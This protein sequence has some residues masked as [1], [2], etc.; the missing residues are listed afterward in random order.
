MKCSKWLLKGR[1]GLL[2]IAVIALVSAGATHATTFGPIP[3]TVQDGGYSYTRNFGTDPAGT[4]GY[5][6]GLDVACPPPGMVFYS[7]FWIG[8]VPY[9]LSTDIR[10][11]TADSLSWLLKVTNATGIT[12]TIEWD[13]T[14]LPATTDSFLIKYNGTTV[15]MRDT[16]QITN[17]GGEDYTIV[18]KHIIP[19]VQLC[20]LTVIGVKADTVYSYDRYFGFSIGATDAFDVG[21]D[22]ACPPPGFVFY[23]Y[24]WITTSPNYLC[25]DI[26]SSTVDSTTWILKIA[27]AY[28]YTDTVK[29]DPTC[30]PEGAWYLVD[31]DN[32]T[33]DMK[34][35]SYAVYSGEQELHIK[36]Y[37]M[38]LN[39]GPTSIVSPSDTVTCGSIN[40][41]EAWVKNFGSQAVTFDVSC[42]ID[43]YASTVNV[44]NLPA[45]DS[46]L[47]A[48]ADWTAPVTPGTYTM[49]VI[50]QLAGDANPAND[51]LSKDI[52]VTC[53]PVLCY[54]ELVAVPDSLSAG[55]TTTITVKAMNCDSQLITTYHN[56]APVTLDLVGVCAIPDEI[57]WGGAATPITGTCSAQIDSCKFVGGIAVVTLAY[58]RAECIQVTATDIDGKTGTSNQICWYPLGASY[59]SVDVPDTAYVGCPFTVTVTPRDIY[60][61]EVTAYSYWI[62]FA[63]NELCVKLPSAQLITGATEYEVKPTNTA[64][65][66]RIGVLTH[67]GEMYGWSDPIVVTMPVIDQPN[68]IYASDFPNDQGCCIV[69][70][71]DFS[72][73]HPGVS[74]ACPTIDYY[75]IYAGTTAVAPEFLWGTVQ[76]T[77]PTEVGLDSM[78]VVVTTCGY[79]G[80]MYFWVQAVDD[81]A[82]NG[83]ISSSGKEMVTDGSHN[84]VH[85]YI[86]AEVNP[87]RLS[88]IKG[89][90][91]SALTG[92][93]VGQAIDNIAPTEASFVRAMDTQ[94]DLGGSITITWN[95]SADDRIVAQSQDMFG[96][97][98]CIYGVTEYL[99]YRDEE[100]VGS[101]ARGISEYVD[102]GVEN[103]HPYNYAI[104]AFDGTNLSEISNIDD[105]IAADNTVLGDFTSDHIVGLADLVLFAD[106]YGL[107]QSDI[108]FDWLYDLDKDG[109]IGLS[110][111]TIFVDQYGTKT[112]STSSSGLNSEAQ[113]EVDV[114]PDATNSQYLLNI[115]AVNVRSLVGYQLKVKYDP[116]LATFVTAKSQGLLRSKG[117]ETPLFLVKKGYGEVT[118][119][120]VLYKASD[121]T[122]P[123][124][125]GALVQLCFVADKPEFEL[126]DIRLIDIDGNIDMLKSITASGTEVVNN[127][128]PKL[129]ELYQNHPNPFVSETAIKY[130][131]PKSTAVRL[132]IYNIAGQEICTLVEGNKEAGYYTVKW[133]GKDNSGL[134]VNSGIYFCRLKTSDRTI[135]KKLIILQ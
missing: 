11:S 24:F 25:A 46:T 22:S 66:L 125:E 14:A 28:Q 68:V 79:T 124:G 15:N 71:W 83:K 129:C 133:D 128:L 62:W 99:I 122:A 95:L 44:A 82:Y 119:A 5:D 23:P 63:A 103:N 32:G 17:T 45:G 38:L 19:Q 48:F 4:D 112:K 114:T 67:H 20:A 73:N 26:R 116:E 89:Q 127:N 86:W 102:V 64:D 121:E 33:I 40:D 10:S 106:H 76:A 56:V 36:Y 53:V 42:S 6:D 110:D 88:E 61:N 111:F 80:V 132:A 31:I 130:A 75:Q 7:Y 135:Q 113:I 37:K 92:P 50:T 118:I 57:H 69:L 98:Y 2:L 39:V 18:Y 55:E 105:A 1:A 35:N 81:D 131:I 13:P 52:Y 87:V 97:P 115:K 77:D 30:L 94:D 107:T 21:I 12:Y 120:N 41:V 78:R 117:G 47:V 8:E 34:T 65:S 93:A 100:L 59:F 84:A 49:T 70:T 29:W 108:T 58:D 90:N 126:T 74:D 9:Y 104:Y 85:K 91:T 123:S 27:N 54:F 43:G 101:V 72:I 60:G 96:N 3:V 16:N 134:R 109:V 51:T